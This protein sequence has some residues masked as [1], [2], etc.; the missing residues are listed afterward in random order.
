[1]GGLGGCGGGLEL[2]VVWE[3]VFVVVGVEEDL[4][5]DEEGVLGIGGVGIVE[6]GI[7]IIGDLGLVMIDGIGDLV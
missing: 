2:V 4:W 7:G 6:E 1:M 5:V 3:R